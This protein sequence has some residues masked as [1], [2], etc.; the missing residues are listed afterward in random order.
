M[1]NSCKNL[2]QSVERSYAW[3]VENSL[4]EIQIEWWKSHYQVP[5]K[6]C[7]EIHSDLKISSRIDRIQINFLSLDLLRKKKKITER[8]VHLTIW[9]TQKKWFKL[10]RYLLCLHFSLFSFLL[11][12]AQLQ[13]LSVWELN[14]EEIFELY[15]IS[16][17]ARFSYDTYFKSW[18]YTNFLLF[19]RW[20]C[21]GIN[22]KVSRSMQKLILILR[23]S[24]YAS[25]TSN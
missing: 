7:R 21:S 16:W 2:H 8:Q 3:L 11:N 24:K 22:S 15:F 17:L 5:I 1:K 18:I 13:C 14:D 23:Q 20:N 19:W 12:Q 6:V 4:K 9:N 10:L 25:W